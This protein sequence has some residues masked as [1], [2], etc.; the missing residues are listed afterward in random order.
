M[1]EAFR[2]TLSATLRDLARDPVV[3][4][5]KSVVA[6]RTGLNVNVNSDDSSSV[7]KSIVA[8]VS[9]WKKEGGG[10]GVLRLADKALNDF[11][12]CTALSIATE[13]NK[14]GEY[15]LMLIHGPTAPERKRT[16]AQFSSTLVLVIQTS[17]SRCPLRPTCNQSSWRT[18]TRHLSFSTEVIPT[19]AMRATSHPCT[20]MF[21]L[22]SGR[23]FQS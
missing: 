7:E 13:F 6:Y 10:S 15:S 5:F 2:S 18:P 1:F 19:V 21:T 3:V 16:L 14:P 17:S 4:G 11:V 22:I 12:V 23:C 8:T 9:S 20:R